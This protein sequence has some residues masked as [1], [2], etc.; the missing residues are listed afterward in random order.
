MA[1]RK[2]K[3]RETKTTNIVDY[4]KNI[5]S[6]LDEKQLLFLDYYTKGI[7][8]KKAMEL[9]G[10]S[11]SYI[12]KTH[13][14]F[15]EGRLIQMALAELNSD[16]PLL[17]IKMQNEAIKDFWLNTM[18]NTSIT[19]QNRLKASE[20]LAKANG[21]FTTQVEINGSVQ[22]NLNNNQQSYEALST[23]QLLKLIEATEEEEEDNVEDVEF[24]EINEVKEE[25][26]DDS[27]KDK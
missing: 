16:V 27:N 1:K 9:A 25:N 11:P 21:M 13:K 5:L 6:Q 17:K 2:T 8:C 20:N 23:E 15:L 14:H 18:K 12:K 7:E 22:H 3:E 24:E 19:M 10:Y 4:E 26:E